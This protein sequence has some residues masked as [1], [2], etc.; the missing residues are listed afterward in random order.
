MQK[1]YEGS[2]PKASRD[3]NVYFTLSVDDEGA[4]F[5]DIT[6]QDGGGTCSVHQFRVGDAVCIDQDKL[7]EKLKG[8]NNNNLAF[9]RV[10]LKQIF[11]R[12]AG[13]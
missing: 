6:G 3:G 12:K 5:V 7:E 4:L 8:T 9:L 10:V 1:I 11:S 2:A 13:K